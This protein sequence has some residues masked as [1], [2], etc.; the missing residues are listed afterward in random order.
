MISTNIIGLLYQQIFPQAEIC[1]ALMEK[2][3]FFLIWA[4]SNLT[5]PECNVNLSQT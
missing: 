4:A 2:M 1:V 3:A 5:L